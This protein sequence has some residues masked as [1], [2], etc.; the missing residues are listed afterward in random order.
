MNAA[1]HVN[2]FWSVPCVYPKDYIIFSE[3]EHCKRMG[4]ILKGS[5]A[6][7]H[8]DEHGEISIMAML[9]TGDTFGDILLFADTPYYMGHLIVY[10]PATIQFLHK[11]NVVQLLQHDPDF[12]NWFIRSLSNKAHRINVSN[13]ILQQPS[14][15][16]KLIMY[17][18]QQSR[19][20]QSPYV[21]IP[22]MENLAAE[23]NVARPSVSRTLS[24]LIK[25]GYL[26]RNRK[27]YTL[28]T[29]MC[30]I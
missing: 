11:D 27:T 29:A 8:Y 3:G 17:F 12:K 20:L 10:E 24:E 6:L 1:Q 5:V 15:K 19:M 26:Q 23:L 30:R 4:K 28:N 21:H 7:V 25:E 14:L 16:Q 13:K 22:S 18:E 2:A 9:K